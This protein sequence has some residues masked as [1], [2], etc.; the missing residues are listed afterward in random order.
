M[1]GIHFGPE[2]GLI[3]TLGLFLLMGL[4]V[5]VI[6]KSGTLIGIHSNLK[7]PSSNLKV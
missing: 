4:N 6:K 3:G 7:K 1:D 5:Y 2:G